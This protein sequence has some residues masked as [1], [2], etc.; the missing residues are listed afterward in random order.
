[1]QIYCK[2]CFKKLWDA[3]Y[4]PMWMERICERCGH[5]C[6]LGDGDSYIGGYEYGQIMGIE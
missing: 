1:M 2:N 3:D 4:N 6:Y 5:R